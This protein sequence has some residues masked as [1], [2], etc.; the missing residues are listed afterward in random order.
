MKRLLIVL[1]FIL[2]IGTMP[3]NPANAAPYD[4]DGF[5]CPC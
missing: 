4:G 1:A 5:S 2:A 3:V